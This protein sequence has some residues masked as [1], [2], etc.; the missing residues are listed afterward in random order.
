MRTQKYYFKITLLISILLGII[1]PCILGVK[2][3]TIVAISFG[4]I[5]FIYAIALFSITFLVEGRR[6]KAKLEGRGQSDPFTLHDIQEF[7]ALYEITTKKDN[8]AQ[9]KLWS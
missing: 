8:E 1:L 7:Q 6:S 9:K 5:W 4:L 2:D 3:P